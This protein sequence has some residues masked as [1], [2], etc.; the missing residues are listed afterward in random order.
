MTGT[1]SL[2]ARLLDD[3]APP[4]AP[5]LLGSLWGRDPWAAYR[6][7]RTQGDVIWSPKHRSFFVFSSAAVVE[8]L[9]N[10]ELKADYP[11]RA[12]R[13]AL[14][15]TI[16]DLEGADHRRLRPPTTARLS[17]RLVARDE[18]EWLD[19]VIAARVATFVRDGGGDVV[20]A[21][22]V[23][24][25]S[26]VIARLLG[27]P[28]AEA[29][30]VYEV[31]RGINRYLDTAAGTLGEADEARERLQTYLGGLLRGPVRDTGSALALLAAAS[32]ED[33]TMSEQEAIS[34]GLLLLAAG[35]ETSIG[36]IANAVNILCEFPAVQQ[37]L[38]A[39]ALAPEPFLREVLR[40]DPPMHFAIRYAASDL[41]IAGHDVRS[42]SLVQLCL[43]SANRDAEVFAQPD[44]FDPGRAPGRML[45]FGL[46]R[47]ACPGS[48]IAQVEAIATV[49]SLLAFTT[50][51]HR[52]GVP[53]PAP[54]LM[55][56][57]PER[58]HVMVT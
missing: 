33:G 42:G 54:G 16:V 57:R 12:T 50:S 11:F 40:W 14:G 58:L 15:P 1:E 8:A 43:A 23:P 29:R 19:E 3:E 34:A 18:V 9:R 46:G 25:V 31:L 20:E 10:G 38:R 6:S 13:Q 49:R 5:D 37:R 35:T 53:V 17:A 28:S 36:A 27:C 22:A 39:G 26:T 7:W 41:I 47:H 51:V 56:R 52:H 48:G 45:T 55:F 21:L 24:I 30:W 32:A 4:G 44:D 2:S